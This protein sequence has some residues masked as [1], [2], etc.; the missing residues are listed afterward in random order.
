MEEK[1]GSI[2]EKFA[3][4]PVEQL[5]TLIEVYREDLRAG[6][7]KEIEKAYKKIE[8]LKKEKDEDSKKRLV[9][10]EK[11]IADL[12]AESEKMTSEWRAEQSKM[13]ELSDA[14][15]A[16]DAAKAEVASAMR[17]GDYEKA[18]ALQYGKIPELEE[19]IKKMNADAREY[20]TV[21]PEHIAAVVSKWTGVPAERLSVEEQSK[22][23]NIEDEL[24]KRVVGQ[25]AALS[26]VARAIRRGRMGLKDPKR[27]VGSFIFMGPTGIG[28]TELAKAM[29][30]ELFFDRRAFF[31][32]DM[33]YEFFKD[34]ISLGGFARVWTGQTWQHIMPEVFTKENIE[35][36]SKLGKSLAG[37]NSRKLSDNEVR[38]VRQ[39]KQ[40]GLTY[41]E[42]YDKINH[43]VSLSTLKEIVTYKT[44]KEVK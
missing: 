28:K 14:M 37:K 10:L 36:N 17:A 44:Y 15:A 3:N 1:I 40:N 30:E 11:Q 35:R 39:L 18:S 29:A 23:L 42:I 6:V 13:H 20:K 31:K 4:M 34:K 32:Y 9:A 27:P 5:S 12:T 38:Q 22:L 2:K 41:Q 8:A 26:I 33:S 7:Q 16:L 24:R 43:K 21:L 19:K 25:D